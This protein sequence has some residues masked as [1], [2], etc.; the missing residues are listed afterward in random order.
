MPG[1]FKIIMRWVGLLLFLGSAPVNGQ[2]LQDTTALN[3]VEKDI[4]YIYNLQFNNAR[5]IYTKIIDL[6]G[7]TI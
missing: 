3:L 6:T 1:R 2:L 7:F 4:D 5:E